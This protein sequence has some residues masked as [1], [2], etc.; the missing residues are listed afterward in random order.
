MDLLKSD[1]TGYKD[2]A[3]TNDSVL[4]GPRVGNLE[5]DKKSMKSIVKYFTN[6]NDRALFIEGKL[7]NGD[8][9]RSTLVM[10]KNPLSN[11]VYL[12]VAIQKEKLLHSIVEGWIAR[13]L[14]FTSPFF[15]WKVYKLKTILTL[16]ISLG[17]AQ[18]KRS[19]I[20]PNIH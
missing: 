10:L 17:E 19:N 18:V 14:F 13:Y 1:F 6:F 3:R 15:L 8:F 9:G 7:N 12:E 20:S 2:I 4:F 11:R 5:I 16:R